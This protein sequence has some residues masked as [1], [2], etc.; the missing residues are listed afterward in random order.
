MQILILHAMISLQTK[1]KGNV[2]EKGPT[3]QQNL[4]I[5][6]DSD[7][8]SDDGPPSVFLFKLVKR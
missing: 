2:M 8:P 5:G 7:S 6:S 1:F 3:V 4:K